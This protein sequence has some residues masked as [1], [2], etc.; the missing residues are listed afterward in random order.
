MKVLP[1]NFAVRGAYT[2]ISAKYDQ[3]TSVAT[4]SG[5]AVGV[6]A[7]NKIPGVPDS[8]LYIDLAWRS[9][10]WLMKPRVTYTEAAVD[11]RLIGKMYADSTN[12]NTAA[13]YRLWGARVSHNI[14]NGPH[15]LTMFGRVDNISDKVYVSSVVVDQVTGAYYESGMPRNWILGVK[16]SLAMN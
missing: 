2:L 7:G 16:Y 14:K 3:N 10:D 8:Q 12:L 9:T 11:Y 13:S 1:L 4:S 15:T 6:N 5:G